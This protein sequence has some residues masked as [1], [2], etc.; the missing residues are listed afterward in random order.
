MGAVALGAS[1]RVYLGFNLEFPGLGLQHTVHAEQAVVILAHSQRETHLQAL[2][3]SAPPCGHCRQFLRETQAQPLRILLPGEAE[4]SLQEL[5]PQSFGPEDLGQPCCILEAA[6]SLPRIEGATG[7]QLAQQAA[8]C[9]WAP[10]SRCQSGVAL[11]CGER[12]FFGSYLENAAFNPSLNPLQYAIVLACSQGFALEEIEEV[13]FWERSTSVSLHS[14]TV[15]ICQAL[16]RQL[17]LFTDRAEGRL[18]DEE[19]PA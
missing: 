16:P 8:S 4:Y 13:H 11:R 18:P 14:A 12:W 2:A 17:L 3:V 15:D 10:Y 5:L 1:G 7:Q 9:G 19:A 6:A